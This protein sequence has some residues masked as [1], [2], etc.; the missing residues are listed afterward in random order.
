MVSV[1]VIVT[2]VVA[3]AENVGDVERDDERVYVGDIVTVG[4]RV[5]AGVRVNDGL[6]VP[7]AEASASYTMTVTEST[8][9]RSNRESAEDSD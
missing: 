9:T 1:T 6:G 3:V 8:G 5:E 7:L 4:V 2:V